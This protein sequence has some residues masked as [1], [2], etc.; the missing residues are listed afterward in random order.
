MEWIQYPQENSSIEIKQQIAALEETAWPSDSD[1]KTFPSAPDTY[2]TSFVL[3]ENGRAVCH[4]G[5]RKKTFLHKGIAY[6]AYGLSEVVTHP[7]YQRQGIGTRM[8]Q[9][10]ADFILSENPDISI[11][12]CEPKRVG[13]YTGGGWQAANGT[14]LVGGTKDEPFRSDSLGLITMVRFLSD[15]VE[16]HR[17]DFENADVFLELGEHQLW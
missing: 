1:E 7:D 8:I 9:K 3:M 4:V 13:F 6:L 10:A 12:T 2:V 17:Q 14:C 5:I 15:K 11:F 16:A